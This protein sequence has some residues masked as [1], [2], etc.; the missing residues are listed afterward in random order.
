MKSYRDPA[1]G[2]S[3]CSRIE[4]TMHVQGGYIYLCCIKEHQWRTTSWRS[5]AIPNGPKRRFSRI[6]LGARAEL[7][8][9]K[10]LL[11]EWVSQQT[12]LDLYRKRRLS[13]YRL[14]RARS[15]RLF[16]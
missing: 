11:A 12:V 1:W 13:G 7:D 4:A 3:R 8:A 16:A 10:V 14:C 2:R 5:W 15:R 6:W 9:L